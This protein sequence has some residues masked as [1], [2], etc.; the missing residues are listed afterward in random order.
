MNIPLTPYTIALY[1]DLLINP[2]KYNCEYK[3]LRE[4]FKM[5]EKVTPQDELYEQYIS[6]INKP[7]PKP[8]FYI[9]M[10]HTFP[11]LFGADKILD[12]SGKLVGHRLG[13]KLEFIKP[14]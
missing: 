5:A 10:R 12:D 7:L 11:L 9:I 14:L 2:Q 6:Y 13:Y 4:C 8:V 3:P 1:T